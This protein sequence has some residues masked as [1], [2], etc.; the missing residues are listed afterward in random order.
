MCVAMP[1]RVLSVMDGI[2][3]VDFDGN[4]I[5]AR[6]DLVQVKEGDRVLVHAGLIIQKLS[7]TEAEEMDAIFAELRSAADLREIMGE[8]DENR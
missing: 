2:A 5:E 1:G 4:L 3:R 6:A 8:S 7:A